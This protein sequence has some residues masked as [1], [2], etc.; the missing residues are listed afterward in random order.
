MKTKI[1][2][3]LTTCFILILNANAQFGGLQ[4]ITKTKDTGA[5]ATSSFNKDA[6][7]KD[8]GEILSG[9][10]SAYAEFLQS[11]ACVSKALGLK[12]QNESLQAAA[13]KIKSATSPDLKG[14][15]DTRTATAENIAVVNELLKA[16][17]QVDDEGKQDLKKSS[18]HMWRGV[19]QEAI[20]TTKS[21]LAAKVLAEAIKNNPMQAVSLQSQFQDLQW[22]AKNLPDDLKLLQ[23][24]NELVDKVA[25]DNGID[26]S[27]IKED[28]GLAGPDDQN[29]GAP[30]VPMQSPSETP[31][32]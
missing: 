32:S 3:I 11:Y 24:R 23:E 9:F 6:L 2:T 8:Q 18:I 28:S 14:I 1:L 21:A 5:A 30:T 25:K 31:K 20:V 17:K 15:Q 26:L 7:L 16:G 27:K 12:E 13:N 22:L 10:S 4:N 19:G 29:A